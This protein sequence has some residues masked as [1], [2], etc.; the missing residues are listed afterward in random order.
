MTGKRMG[1][2]LGVILAVG[3]STLREEVRF[4]RRKSQASV[5]E[6]DGGSNDECRRRMPSDSVSTPPLNVLISKN[7]VSATRKWSAIV[8]PG[9]TSAHAIIHLL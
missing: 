5:S 9:F 4:D 2:D 7:G 8:A 6:S 3:G 1:S